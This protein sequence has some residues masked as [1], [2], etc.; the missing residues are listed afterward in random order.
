VTV[1]LRTRRREMRWDRA[2]YHEK[3]GLRE[4][5]VRVNLPTPIRQVLVPIRRVII[6][7]KGLPNLPRQ[8]IEPL[9]SCILQIILIFIPHHSLS[10]PQLHH[11]CRTQSSVIPLYRSMPWLLVDNKC[12]RHWVQH[13]PSTAYTE[14]S[15]HQVQ[16]TPNAPFMEYSILQMLHSPSTA[17]YQDC[18]SSLHSHDYHLTPECS[19]Q[20]ASLYNR[21]PSA[22]S[23][24]E[25]TGKVTLSHSQV[26]ESTNWWIESQHPAHHPAT[27]SKSWSK[28]AQTR[29]PSASPNSLDYGLQVHISKF[30]LSLHP[31]LDKPGF[32]VHH[33]TH[34]MTTSGCMLNFTRSRPPRVS[35]VILDY[36]LQVHLQT[37]NITASECISELSRSSFSGVLRIALKN[38]L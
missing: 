21:P 27:V 23:P 6:P 38:R 32:Q 17:S 16:Y 1:K 5:R 19:L 24:W 14:C 11:H 22:S 35:P 30:A 37:C 13:T 4:F 12:S 31:N 9:I 26:C 7:I 25:V 20:R 33:L 8:V 10:P 3:L 2:N 34:S 15:S 18:F 36:R 28:L 29:P